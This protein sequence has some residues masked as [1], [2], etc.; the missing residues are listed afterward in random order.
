MD[1]IPEINS[2]ITVLTCG[3]GRVVWFHLKLAFR[4]KR[5]GLQLRDAS[6]T[7]SLPAFI[8]KRKRFLGALKSSV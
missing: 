1:F 6:S 2:P 5:V 3:R 7:L 8:E 4:P